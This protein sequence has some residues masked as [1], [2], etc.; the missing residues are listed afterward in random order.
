MESLQAQYHCLWEASDYP[1]ILVLPS[2]NE[3]LL[4][5]IQNRLKLNR[6]VTIITP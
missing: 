3:T 1:L 2:L 6:P 5:L 4:R